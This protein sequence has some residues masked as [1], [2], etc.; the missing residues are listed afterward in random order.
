MESFIDDRGTSQGATAW[1]LG[2]TLRTSSS[3]ASAFVSGCSTEIAAL[4]LVA[5]GVGLSGVT[6]ALALDGL[7]LVAGWSAEAVILAWV[8]RAPASRERWCSPSSSSASPRF[9]P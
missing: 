2:V 4:L 9:T 7:A 8:S 3:A 6:L 5:V 1:V